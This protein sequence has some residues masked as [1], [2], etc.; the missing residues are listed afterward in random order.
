MGKKS[1]KTPDVV[2]AAEREGEF[3]RETARD[4]LYADRPDQYNSLGSNTWQ[5]QSV[6]DPSTGE[7]TTKWTQRQNLSPDMQTLLD[8]DVYTNTSLGQTAAGLTG[9]AQGEMSAPLNW[10]QFGQGRQGP[11][12]AGPVGGVNSVTGNNRFAYDSQDS[13]DVN[14]TTGADTAFNYDGVSRRQGAEDA[15]YQRA[16]N[17]LDPQFEQ[18]RESLEVRLRNR[19]LRAGDQAYESEMSRFGNNR[20][21]AYEQA[22]LGSVSEGRTEDAQSFGQYKDSYGANRST[23]QQRFGQD[24]AGG[25]YD[26]ARDQQ[27]FG[28]AQNAFGTNL[29]AEQQQFGQNLAA[30]QNARAADAQSFQQEAGATDRANALRDQQIQEYLGK[31]GQTL[32][33]INALRGS[34]NTEQM[35][36]TFGSGA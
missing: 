35:T 33:E 21:D 4:A 11:E 19:G 25:Q 30:G 10:D 16:T 9:R 36:N 3:S 31:R 26:L 2:G 13:R 14:S 5:Q 15:A 20:N 29:G 27:G 34:Q 8:Q 1:P 18:D 6:R 22:R 24:L 32:S 23:E 28:Q 17:R 7:M 12:S